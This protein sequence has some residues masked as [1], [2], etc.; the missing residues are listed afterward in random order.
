MGNK[1]PVS[2]WRSPRIVR[3]ADAPTIYIDGSRGTFH[4]GDVVVE[5]YRHRADEPG[6][7]DV[8]VTIIMPKESYLRSISEAAD[9]SK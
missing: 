7:A 3:N 2:H 6:I 9:L 4:K 1:A 5:G 8:V